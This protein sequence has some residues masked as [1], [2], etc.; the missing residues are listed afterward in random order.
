MDAEEAQK[1]SDA[2]LIRFTKIQGSQ[3]SWMATDE[4]ARRALQNE[5]LLDAT[6]AAIRQDRTPKPRY[7]PYGSLAAVARFLDSGNERAIRRLLQ[8]MDTWTAD[9]Q[10]FAIAPWAGYKRVVEGTLELKERYGWF[11][12]YMVAS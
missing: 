7:V 5:N 10:E 11:P 9:E 4:L 6:C 2:E 1:L 12:K 8:E 3:A